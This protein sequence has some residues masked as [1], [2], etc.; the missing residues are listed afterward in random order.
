MP[1]PRRPVFPRTPCKKP[2]HCEARAHTGCGERAERCQ[3]QKKRGER[4][5]AVKISSVRREAAQKFWAP[6]QGH[7][8]PLW[9]CAGVLR[10]TLL[11]CPKFLRCL[12][13][14]AGNFDRGHSLTSLPLPLAALGSLPTT[15][16]RTGLGMTRKFFRFLLLPVPAAP[17]A[18]RP[19][20]PKPSR[21]TADSPAPQKIRPAL[22]CEADIFF[23]RT[24][25]L[26]V[27]LFFCICTSSVTR[28]P[29]I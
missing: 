11:R 6:Q 10:M 13:A 4:V 9:I 19:P 23:H 27:I 21:L 24:V 17:V 22:P 29:R 2:C 15:S 20:V 3:W 14:D 25:R 16:L 18:I 12:T 26:K 7:P 8:R 28:S 1:P 5:A